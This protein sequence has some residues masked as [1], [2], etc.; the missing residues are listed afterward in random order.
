MMLVLALPTD[1]ERVY[2]RAVRIFEPEE[3]GEAFAATRG[4]TIPSR[5]RTALA[6]DGR[7]LVG[8][9]RALAPRKDP[10]AV[11]RW[12]VRR[13]VLTVRTAILVAGTAALLA[14]NLA[15]PRAP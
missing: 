5:L 13:I 7:D 6:E 3:I 15:N 2:A 12:S 10:I 11:Q 8:R 1:A 4:P 14:V 9:F